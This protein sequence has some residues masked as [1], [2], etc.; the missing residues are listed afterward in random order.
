MTDSSQPRRRSLRDVVDAV[1]RCK[2]SRTAQHATRFVGV[3]RLVQVAQRNV[4][5]S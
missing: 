2:R 5:E 3:E 1:F 4:G